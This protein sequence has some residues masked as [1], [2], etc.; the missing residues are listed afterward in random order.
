MAENPNRD[1]PLWSMLKGRGY[2]QTNWANLQQVLDG[3]IFHSPSKSLVDEI[4]IPLAV[5][6]QPNEKQVGILHKLKN[7][8]QR[9]GLLSE[10]IE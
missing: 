5:F 8:N 7:V 3:T 2:N 4:D 6:Y 1:A 9:V 10:I